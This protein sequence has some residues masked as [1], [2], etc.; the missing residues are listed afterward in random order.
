MCTFTVQ[1]RGCHFS[2]AQVEIFCLS[3]TH[4]V[5]H[6]SAPLV[7]HRRDKEGIVFPLKEVS[8]SSR[9]KA[10]EGLTKCRICPGHFWNGIVLGKNMHQAPGCC[11]EGISY[12]YTVKRYCGN[13]LGSDKMGTVHGQCILWGLLRQKS[14][15]E[16][17]RYKC[18]RKGIH[19][20]KHCKED[21]KFLS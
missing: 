13:S 3:S 10:T 14:P 1:D 8:E 17:L 16:H 2:H 18:T 11:F 19:I 5:C 9:K 12:G 4:R 7:H 15:F 6:G 21:L 20:G